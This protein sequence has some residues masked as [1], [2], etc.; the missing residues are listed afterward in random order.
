MDLKREQV[1]S[2]GWLIWQVALRCRTALDR[3]LAPLGL[4]NAQY[5]LLAA[6]SQLSRSGPPPSQ[7][8]L[9]DFAGLEPMYVSKLARTLQQ[10]GLIERRDDPDDTRAVRLTLTGSGAELVAAAREKVVALDERILAPL[11]GSSS[12]D[13]AQLH[14]RL[15][16]LLHHLDKEK[17]S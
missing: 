5:G 12:D 2:T 10:A 16:T 14:G 1:P 13:T 3:A 7:R 4:T 17:P 9:A 8:Q 15:L 6:L 11:G